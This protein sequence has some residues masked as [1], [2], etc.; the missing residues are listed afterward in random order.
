MPGF[1]GNLDTKVYPAGLI[2]ANALIFFSFVHPQT[3]L[4]ILLNQS[5]AVSAVSDR[6]DTA[7]K[8]TGD[9]RRYDG[10][11]FVITGF[12][13]SFPCGDVIRAGHEQMN[14]AIH[15]AGKQ[16]IFR[17]ILIRRWYCGCLRRRFD[18]LE[19]MV[20]NV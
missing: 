18:G 11:Q 6:P 20:L 3:C 7:G 2:R 14:M 4:M 17:K 13:L 12:K 15:Q 5:L 1:S 9:M 19:G 10:F 16:G 8:V